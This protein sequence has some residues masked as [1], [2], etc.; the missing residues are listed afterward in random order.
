MRL[1]RR[2]AVTIEKREVLVTGSGSVR[3]RVYCEHCGREVQM[4]S[5]A[6]AAGLAGLPE[7]LLYQRVEAGTTHFVERPN[8]VILVC[9]ESLGE[10]KL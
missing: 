3:E 1:R 10:I 9:S 4:L 8:G 7:R 2:I 6:L 5:V